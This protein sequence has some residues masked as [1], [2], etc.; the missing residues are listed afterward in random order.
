MPGPR[1]YFCTHTPI[2]ESRKCNTYPSLI[3]TFPLTFGK[4]K[5]T[6]GQQA[7]AL[8]T[9]GKGKTHTAGQEGVVS[10]ALKKS[11]GVLS[12]NLQALEMFP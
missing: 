4:K 11:G 5:K 12:A 2:R 8:A 10:V 1:S 9:W 3:P 7:A 6:L